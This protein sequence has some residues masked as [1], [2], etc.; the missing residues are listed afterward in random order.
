[1]ACPGSKVVATARESGSRVHL[2]DLTLL[3][4]EVVNCISI[5]P[6][7]I[8]KLPE[9]RTAAP[10]MRCVVA[11]LAARER[12]MVDHLRKDTWYS[13]L[14]R[15]LEGASRISRCSWEGVRGSSRDSLPASSMKMEAL[16]LPGTGEEGTV[17]GLLPSL[18]VS[19]SP[20][21]WRTRCRP[22]L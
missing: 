18:E 11:L 22:L 21:R 13:A 5:R 15:D 7:A 12:L 1:M 17:E 10:T 14:S 16:G 8:T 2:R 6:L 20:F 9:R 4:M 3:D 19:L